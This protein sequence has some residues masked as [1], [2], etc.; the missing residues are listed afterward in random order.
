MRLTWGMDYLQSCNTTTYRNSKQTFHCSG[1]WLQS[2]NTLVLHKWHTSINDFAFVFVTPGGGEKC[3]LEVEVS[4]N[5]PAAGCAGPVAKL[6]TRG[7]SCEAVRPSG[8]EVQGP[9]GL[10]VRAG[11][12]DIRQWVYRN[13][14]CALHWTLVLLL[15]YESFASDTDC[16]RVIVQFHQ[17][18]EDWS[19][20]CNTEAQT[21]ATVNRTQARH[22]GALWELHLRCDVC[23]CIDWMLGHMNYC[24]QCQAAY[25]PNPHEKDVFAEI[26]KMVNDHS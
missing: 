11:N 5:P 26:P 10:D 17:C 7:M 24:S 22:K 21:E 13:W 2:E 18:W 9:K 8:V 1:G 16:C 19:T 23:R 25:Q 6:T 14:E 20:Y 15:G 4:K 3:W 12:R